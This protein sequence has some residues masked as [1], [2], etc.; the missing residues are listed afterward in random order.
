MKLGLALGY[1]GPVLSLPLDAVALAERLGYDSVWTGEAWGSDAVTPLAYLAARTERVR[2]GTAVMQVAARAPTMCAMQAQTVDAL[3]GGHRFIAGLGVS[4]PQV[5]EGWYGQPWGKP[6]WRLRDYVSIMRKVFDREAP[7]THDGR[8]ISIPYSGPGSTGLGK[9]LRSILHTNPTLPIWLGTMGPASIRLAAEL[10]DGWLPM[11]A[12]PQQ[13]EACRPLLAEG[14]L[15]SSGVRSPDKFEIQPEVVVRLTDDV[16][17]AIADEKRPVAFYVG[18]MGH[19]SENYHLRQ[20]TVAGYPDE[21]HRIMELYQ[22][23]KREEASS[24]VPDAYVD[25]RALIGPAERIAE[26]FRLWQDSIVT[27]LTIRTGQFEAVELMAE[28]A[29]RP[30][31]P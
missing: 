8:E 13:I 21:A 31:S 28:L 26:R 4:G 29:S 19:P 2:L 14:F 30:T 9:P 5:V 18:G 20:M 15:R 11:S 6:Y 25:D 24:A 27:G 22:R 12:S 10:C 23:G 17:G 7:V 1:S 3:A 16:H